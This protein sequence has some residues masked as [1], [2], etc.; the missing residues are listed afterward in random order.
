[1]NRDMVYEYEGVKE[2]FEDVFPERNIGNKV[3]EY[4]F[5]G[6]MS[7]LFVNNDALNFECE[8]TSYLPDGEFTAD[9][10]KQSIVNWVKDRLEEI[11]EIG[12]INWDD[13]D[14]CE[15]NDAGDEL[16]YIARYKNLGGKINL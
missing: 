12:D 8:G 1:M 13:A 4:D 11:D 9:E 14:E 5:Y 15:D 10:L 16:S 3:D 7:E 2:I 6:T